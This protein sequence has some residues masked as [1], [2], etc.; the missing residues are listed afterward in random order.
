VIDP[1]TYHTTPF[2]VAAAKMRAEIEKIKDRAISN[3]V[4]PEGVHAQRIGQVQGLKL[5][6]EILREVERETL[7]LTEKP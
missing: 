4:E 1:A 5:A 7:G 3:L 2:R 6:A